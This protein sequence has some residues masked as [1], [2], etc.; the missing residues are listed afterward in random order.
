[1]ELV[2]RSHDQQSAI[3]LQ[4]LGICSLTRLVD[5]SQSKQRERWVY[6]MIVTVTI[7]VDPPP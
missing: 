4:A 6:H 7:R 3:R 1:M 2:G 5:L